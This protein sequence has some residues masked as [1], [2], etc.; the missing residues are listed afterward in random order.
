VP[1]ST[2]A[3]NEEFRGQYSGCTRLRTRGRERQAVEESHPAP[4]GKLYLSS[5]R[6][7]VDGKKHLAEQAAGLDQ[8]QWPAPIVQLFLDKST[9]A[10]ALAGARDN[11][12]KKESGQRCEAAF[13]VA[14]YQLGKGDRVN[15]LAGFQAAEQACKAV[16][17]YL[18]NEATEVELKRLQP[19]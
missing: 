5:Q 14:E 1:C 10:A 8:K 9:A 3:Q 16:P 17:D 13:Y 7:G 2:N 18:E 6:L 12:P 4:T 11:D 19:R 15:G